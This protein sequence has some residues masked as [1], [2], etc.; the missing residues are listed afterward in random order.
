MKT[1]RIDNDEALSLILNGGLTESHILVTLKGRFKAEKRSDSGAYQFWYGPSTLDFMLDDE[2]AA[3]IHFADAHV[4]LETSSVFDAPE[5][6]GWVPG[7]EQNPIEDRYREINLGGG[8]VIYS[9]GRIACFGEYLDPVPIDRIPEA[10]G[11]INQLL[12]LGDKS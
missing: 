5:F 6:E 4:E 3:L 11:L 10:A 1:T 2:L 9:D 8:F 7:R 12:A